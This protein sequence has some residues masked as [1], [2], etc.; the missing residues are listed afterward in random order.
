MSLNYNQNA[1][2]VALREFESP[3]QVDSASQLRA[4]LR[5]TDP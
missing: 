1:F 4:R 5:D 3:G 2:L